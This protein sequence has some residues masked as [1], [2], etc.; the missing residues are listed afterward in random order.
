MTVSP[1]RRFA[2]EVGMALASLG[3]TPA[4]GKLLGWLLICD[5]PSQSLAQLSDALGLSKGSVSTGVRVLERIG[6]VRRVPSPGSRGH[7][8]EAMPDALIE[9]GSRAGEE[10]AAMR[11]LMERGLALLD[12]EHSPRARRLRTSRDFYAFIEREVPKLLEQFKNDYRHRSEE[13]EGDG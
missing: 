7:V 9:I 3:M 6:L 1:E 12:D 5:P 8:Y 13:G 2:E 10:Y 4:Y 11:A